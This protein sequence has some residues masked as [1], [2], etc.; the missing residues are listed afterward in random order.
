MTSGFAV[1]IAS[2][3]IVCAMLLPHPVGERRLISRVT[4]APEGEM[5]GFSPVVSTA[6]RK[7]GPGY[8]NT[9]LRAQ[10]SEVRV[11]AIPE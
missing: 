6:L 5:A 4:V 2:I 9:T 1:P 3:V 7:G 10:S 11:T 8:L